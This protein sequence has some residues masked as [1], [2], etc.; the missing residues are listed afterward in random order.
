MLHIQD[1]TLSEQLISDI[2]KWN[3]ETKDGDVWASNQTKWV[4]SLKYATAGTIFSRVMP[5]DL[6]NRIYDELQQR[7]KIDYNPWS[8]STLFYIGMPNSCVN[9]HADYA[10]YNALSIYLNK[11]WDSNWGGWFAFT[12][13]HN[14]EKGD[15]KPAHGHFI[16]PRYNLSILS[17]EME[18]HCTTPISPYAHPRFSVQ[19]FFSKKDKQP[20]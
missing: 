5:A 6:S 11:E 12:T 14:Y 9:W 13:E 7:G 20:A 2:M 10:D 15:V 4:D 19:L 8:R 16:V 3:D 18:W 1:D 17:T